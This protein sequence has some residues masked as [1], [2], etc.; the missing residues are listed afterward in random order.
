MW[1]LNQSLLRFALKNRIRSSVAARGVCLDATIHLARHCRRLGLDTQSTALHWRVPGDSQ[2][3]EHWALGVGNGLALDLTAVQVDGN[4]RPLRKIGDYPAHFGQ[5]SSY[6]LDLILRAPESAGHTAALRLPVKFI[7]RLQYDMAMYDL[8]HGKALQA[9]TR[10]LQTPVMV[11]IGA[12]QQWAHSRLVALTLRA[13]TPKVLA[14]RPS[15][16][17]HRSVITTRPQMNPNSAPVQF[18]H[19]LARTICAV[20]FLGIPACDA[21]WLHDGPGVN[22][23]SVNAPQAAQARPTNFLQ[24]AGAART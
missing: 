11:A 10:F 22:L 7:L 23:V 1:R 6:P 2:F 12:L 14:K 13:H 18:V 17:A 3:R 24:P 21:P 4:S 19:F 15:E 8:R 20:G 9:L 16:R 5:P